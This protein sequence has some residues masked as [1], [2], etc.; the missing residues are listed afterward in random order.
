MIAILTSLPESILKKAVMEYIYELGNTRQWDKLEEVLTR[1]LAVDGCLNLKGEALAFAVLMDTR[2]NDQRRAFDRYHELCCLKEDSTSYLVQRARAVSFLMQMDGG[3][4][5]RRVFDLWCELV[6]EKLPPEAQYI[7]GR[8]GLLL[9]K[10]LFKNGEIAKARVVYRLFTHLSARIC[11][12]HI[13]AARV[14]FRKNG[15][16]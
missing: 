11:A 13:R 3:G 5:L 1:I 10:N 2:R 16:R 6:C 12:S 14:I 15:D 7:C 9:M 4:M 8:S